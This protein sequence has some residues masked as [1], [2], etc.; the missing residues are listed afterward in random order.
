MCNW[1]FWKALCLVFYCR[2]L[3]EL[4]TLYWYAC[5]KIVRGLTAVGLVAAAEWIARR[6]GLRARVLELLGELAE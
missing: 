6:T 3:D 4:E 2:L 1:K 5:I